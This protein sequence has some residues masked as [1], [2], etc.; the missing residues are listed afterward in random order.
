MAIRE[1]NENDLENILKVQESGYKYELRESPRMFRNRLSA[2]PSGCICYDSN[3]QIYGYTVFH[4]YYQE[5]V[6]FDSD[7]LIIPD[8]PSCIYVHNICVDEM[9]RKRG[10]GS[11]LFNKAKEHAINE[12]YHNITLVSVQDSAIFWQGLGLRIIREA[13]GGYGHNSFLMTMD[14]ENFGV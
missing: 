3:N 5:E 2:Y 7:N 9:Y 4:P 12:R 11:V 8:D 14:L 6:P 1:F 10:I 13:K